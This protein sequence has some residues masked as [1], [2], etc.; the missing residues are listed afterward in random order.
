MTAAMMRDVFGAVSISG[1]RTVRCLIYGRSFQH[2]RNIA[3]R[4]GFRAGW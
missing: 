1:R 3:M 4:L 2:M